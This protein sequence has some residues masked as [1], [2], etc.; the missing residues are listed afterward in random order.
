[1]SQ[2]STFLAGLFSSLFRDEAAVLQ[3]VADTYLN[4]IISD[5]SPDNVVAQSVAYQTQAL[6]V[7]PKVQSVGLFDTA[8]ALKA[9]IDAQIPSLV[10]AN[11]AALNAAAAPATT[12]TPV[13][14]TAA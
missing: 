13:P 6:A 8:T 2:V 4:G 7:L 5:P 14:P 11:T 1:M 12:P 10:A 3:P 9:F